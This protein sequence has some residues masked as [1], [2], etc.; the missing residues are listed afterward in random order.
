MAGFN[1]AGSVGFLVGIVA[2]GLVADAY[3]YRAAFLAVG[4]LEIVLAAATLPAFLRVER[5][6]AASGR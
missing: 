6:R 1:I 3:G 4:G 5:G 2:G